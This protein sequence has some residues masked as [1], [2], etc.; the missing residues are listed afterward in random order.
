MREAVSTDSPLQLFPVTPEE[1]ALV[2]EALKRTGKWGERLA[3]WK[4]AGP[5]LAATGMGAGLG[6]VVHSHDGGGGP[7]HHAAVRRGVRRTNGPKRKV[8]DEGKEPPS[9]GVVPQPA[10]GQARVGEPQFVLRKGLRGWKLVFRGAETVLPD[11][12]GVAYVAVLLMDPPLEPIHGTELAYLAC[13]DAVVE[14]QRNLALDDADTA[15]AKREARRKCQALIDDPGA[16][17]ME[18]D[19]ARAELDEIDEWARKHLR[20]TEGNEQ[21]QVRAIRQAI[22]RLLEGLENARD[23]RGAP[24]EVLRS[25]GEHLDRYLWRPSGRGGRGRNLRVR[26]GLAGR[27]AYEPP[28]GVKWTA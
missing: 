21:R 11:E 14:D 27:F 5:L 16:G 24:A 19:E 18:R 23:A 13:R 6:D 28:D 20:G 15:R 17:E 3:G 12:K 7:E 1:S 25:F 8:E 9:A 4:L 26:A 10:T 22:R 2:V